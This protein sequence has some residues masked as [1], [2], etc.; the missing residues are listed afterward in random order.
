MSESSIIKLS[1]DICILFALEKK[2]GKT[3]I[4]KKPAETL[5]SILKQKKV[6]TLPAPK[7]QR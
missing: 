2:I 7:A 4:L 5:R 1:I 3:V 6:F